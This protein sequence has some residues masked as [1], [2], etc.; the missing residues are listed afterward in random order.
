MAAEKCIKNGKGPAFPAGKG[1]P[2][3]LSGS[4]SQE[5]AGRTGEEEAFCTKRLSSCPKPAQRDV[6]SKISQLE[7]IQAPF[8]KKETHERGANLNPS[9]PLGGRCSCSNLRL[10]LLLYGGLAEPPKTHPSLPRAGSGSEGSSS[11]L[12]AL[13]KDRDRHTSSPLPPQCSLWSG[14][15]NGAHKGGA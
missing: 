4:R 1:S 7:T 12:W 5:Q 8:L 10:I 15:R 11:S 9:G 2:A 14:G 6:P 3:P 13:R